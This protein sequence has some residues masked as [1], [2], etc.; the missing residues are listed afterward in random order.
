VNWRDYPKYRQNIQR[1]FLWCVIVTGA[2]GI[3]QY[4]VAPEWDCF[5]IIETKMV[6]NGT[7]EPMGIRVFSTMHSP[8]PFANVMMAGLLLLFTGRDVLRIPASAAGYLAF[9]LSM[10]RSSW[11]GWLVGMV[12]LLSS[13]KP[14]LQMRLILTILVMSL[15]VVP[16][17]AIEP[18]SEVINAR[19]ESITNLKK[20]Q[21]YKDRSQNYDKQLNVALSNSLGNGIGSAFFVNEKGVL[22]QVV[23]DSAILD[24]FFTLGWFGGIPYL[25]G[26]ILLLFSMFQG[27]EKR[28]DPFV[29]ACHAISL[30]IAT[31]LG[32][33]SVMLSLSGVVFWGFLG[34]SLAARNYYKQ[35]HIN[36]VK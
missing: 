6:T 1:T 23:F 11:G 21:S 30:G 25:G 27:T 9:L 33:G 3:W 16:L 15:C 13:V 2:Y 18:F 4:L 7:P 35:Q 34:M 17:T 31:Q 24:T 10:V 19:I 26:I 8:G 5:W 36:G 28:F 32:L 29:S 22:E 14:R 12:T 20:D